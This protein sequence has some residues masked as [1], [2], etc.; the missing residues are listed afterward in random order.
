VTYVGPNLRPRQIDFILIDQ[1]TKRLLQ[2]AAS[3]QALNMGSDHRTVSMKL[4]L[5]VKP[6][7][8]ERKQRVEWGQVCVEAFRANTERLIPQ[9]IVLSTSDDTCH[10]VE[11]I[12]VKSATQSAS[13]RHSEEGEVQNSAL[14]DEIR[15]LIRARREL[16]H[17]SPER[18][19]LSKRLQK[20]IRRRKREKRRD[21]I[22]VKLEEFKNI[23]HIPRFKTR[24]RSRL[25]VQ[26]M[27]KHGTTQTNRMSI[28]NV[29]ATF[30]EELYSR[31][32]TEDA[33]EATGQVE[34]DNVPAFTENELLKALRSLKNG[35]C[36]DTAGIRA[37]MLKN[38][39]D[40]TRKVLLDLFNSILQGTM[41]TP[42]SWKRSVITVLYKSGDP[43]EA[44]NYRPI[45]IIP[46]LYKLFSKL[47]YSRLYPILE[48]A[49]CPDQAGFR[50]GYSTVDHLFVFKMLQEKT[51]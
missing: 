15:N 30:Y 9:Q 12:L 44:K 2:D 32:V 40:G 16:E 41:E 46:L 42:E 13:V 23:K 4:R 48:Q 18:S 28:A 49:Q 21:Q 45:C 36:K 35:K 51:E 43:T 5:D 20:A 25:I 38:I 37:E 14:D 11:E 33:Y 39:G 10:M 7:I 24:E 6:K 3:I 47:L 26:M 19:V 34:G 1:K 17:V 27:D 8:R 31:R 50:H 29:F 22:K